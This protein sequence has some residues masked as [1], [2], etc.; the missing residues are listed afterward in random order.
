MISQFERSYRAKL[1]SFSPRLWADLGAVRSLE[2]SVRRKVLHF[3]LATACRS[4]GIE[5]ILLGRKGLL[6]LP[7]GW[8]EKN[9]DQA[10]QSV[11]DM[12][13]EYEYRRLLEV[14]AELPDRSALKRWVE[15]GKSSED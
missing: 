11:L 2:D 5:A 4:Q 8:L 15:R 7:S 13:D 14:L 12:D 10:I 6:E 3:L 9:L 1:D